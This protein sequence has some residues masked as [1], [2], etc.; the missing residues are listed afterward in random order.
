[1]TAINM[2]PSQLR[3]RGYAALLRELGAIDFIRFI[4]Q[5]EPGRGDYT[6]D[7]RQWLDALTPE[8]TN[9][10]MDQARNTSK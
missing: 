10:L 9:A 2:T 3:D 4:Q 1:M 8:Q 5:F 7:R 6:Q